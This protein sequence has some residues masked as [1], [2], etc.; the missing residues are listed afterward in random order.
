MEGV[1]SVASTKRPRYIS[2]K[3]NGSGEFKSLTVASNMTDLEEEHPE[4]Y[5]QNMLPNIYT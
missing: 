1:C 3:D 4:I 2:G 5:G